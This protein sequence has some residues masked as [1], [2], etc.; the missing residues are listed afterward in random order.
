MIRKALI[1]ACV[2][3]TVAVLLIIGE[4]WASI[5]KQR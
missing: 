3:H 4:Q 2:I 5:I 1:A